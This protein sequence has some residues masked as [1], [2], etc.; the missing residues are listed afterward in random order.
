MGNKVVITFGKDHKPVYSQKHQGYI[1][2]FTHVPDRKQQVSFTPIAVCPPKHPRTID[3]RFFKFHTENPHVYE[4]LVELCYRV[5]KAG[6]KRYS[7]RTLWETLRWH[8]DI[9]I[10]Q[11]TEGGREHKLNDQFTSRYARL[12]MNQNEAFADLFELRSLKS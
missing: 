7:L 9:E 1:Q 4:K 6:F 11:E 5:R 10:K 12:L 2:G 8:Y 3:E